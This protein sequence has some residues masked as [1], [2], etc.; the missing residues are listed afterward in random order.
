MNTRPKVYVVNNKGFD[1]STAEIHGDIVYL[2]E[3]NPPKDIFNTSRKILEIK[4]KL[5]NASSGD[6]LVVAGNI[7][8]VILAFGVLYERF[9]FVTLLLYDMKNEQYTPRIV[10]KHHL[11]GGLDE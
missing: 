11:T 4:Q 3:D 5:A 1:M 8:L 7:I 2:F 6:Y 9:K 10:A